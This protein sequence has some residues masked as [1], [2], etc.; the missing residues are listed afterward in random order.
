MHVEQSKIVELTDKRV[1]SEYGYPLDLRIS[2]KNRCAH[3]ACSSRA[4]FNGWVL[5]Y[6]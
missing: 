5:R 3:C 1:L 2:C 4:V 6:F